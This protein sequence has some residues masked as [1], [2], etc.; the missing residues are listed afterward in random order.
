[1]ILASRGII[2]PKE[3]YHNRLLCNNIHHTVAYYLIRSYMLPPKEWEHV[4]RRED[5][6]FAQYIYLLNSIYLKIDKH[7]IPPT[8]K[9]VA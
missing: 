6:N 9:I 4:F 5:I 1:M 2:P 7:F 3:W 8:Y